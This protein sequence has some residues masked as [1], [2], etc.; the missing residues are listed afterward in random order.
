MSDE[1]LNKSVLTTTTNTKQFSR[2]LVNLYCY[3]QPDLVNYPVMRERIRSI[4]RTIQVQPDRDDTIAHVSHAI[5]TILM[6]I[7][8]E[9][10][11]ANDN[12]NLRYDAKEM[13]LEIQS[14]IEEFLVRK[15]LLEPRQDD[16]AVTRLV[17]ELALDD[18]PVHKA[19]QL[20]KKK[21]VVKKSKPAAKKKQV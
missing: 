4:L 3:G 11:D 2:A 18:A 9:Y 6:V 7:R 14:V 12:R 5:Q 17:K 20:P 1:Q 10:S 16:E 21:V 8:P 13:D 15:G 19:P